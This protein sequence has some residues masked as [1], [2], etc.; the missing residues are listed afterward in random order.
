MLDPFCGCGTTVDAAHTLK[1]NWIG[2]DLSPKS[3]KLTK[4]RLEQHGIIKNVTNRKGNPELYQQDRTYKHILFG[5]QEGRC[6]GCQTVSA[7]GNMT[8]DP[9]VAKSQESADIPDNLQLLCGAC[10]SMKGHGTQEQ[11]IQTLKNE[12]ILP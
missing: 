11:L 5:L 3:F 12:G 2:I 6:N 1:R 4:L 10:K 8:V 7:F 9:I